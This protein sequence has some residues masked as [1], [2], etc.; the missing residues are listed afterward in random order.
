MKTASTILTVLLLV[1]LTISTAMEEAFSRQV[2]YIPEEVSKLWIEGRSNINEF[3]CQ[4]NQY[5]GEATLFDNPDPEFL[6]DVNDR[7]YLKVEI[8]VDGFECGRSRMNRDLQQAL[9]S[10]EFPEIV[11]VFDNATMLNGPHEPED[12]FEIEVHGSLT[13][14]GNTKNIRFVTKAY[15]LEHDKVRAIGKTT[16]R[17]SDFGVEPPTALMGL[18]K[19]DDE[20]S[21][22]FDLIASENNHACTVCDSEEILDLR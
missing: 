3:E 4:A 22:N 12:A 15:Y 18:V 13:V 19:A 21:V 10:D 16:I 6:L 5:I 11:F 17:M 8:R 9:K 20:L 14:A 1:V 2:T 7:L